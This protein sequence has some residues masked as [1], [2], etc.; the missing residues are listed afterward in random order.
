M[1]Q[2]W[3]YT[4]MREG[5]EGLNPYRIYWKNG[6]TTV[7]FGEDYEDA[8]IKAG[9]VGEKIK[10]MDFFSRGLEQKYIWDKELGDW[11]RK[12]TLFIC[13]QLQLFSETE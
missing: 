2:R 3:E 12:P 5:E 10:E 7:S 9:W 11:T 4:E 8:L 13:E 6:T 1:K